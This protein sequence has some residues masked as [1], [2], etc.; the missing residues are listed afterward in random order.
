MSNV[1]YWGYRINN[2]LAEFF[3]S[4]LDNNR[5]RQGWGYNHDQDLRKEK[6]ISD[7]GA[8]R[9][10]PIFH[11]VKKGDFLLIPHLPSWD[12]IT[13]AQATEDFDKGYEYIIDK[14]YNDF[15]HIFPAKR[16]KV[17]NRHNINVSA[18]IKSTFKCVSRF[19]NIDHCEEDVQHIISLSSGDVQEKGSFQQ[20]WFKAINE[21]FD[22]KG[23]S[24]KLYAKLTHNYN[25]SDWEFMLCEGFKTLLPENVTVET[26]WNREENKHGSD[27]FIKIPGIFE[28]TY[29]I[30][31][32]IKDYDGTVSEDVVN[33]I[34]KVEE[35][36]NNHPGEQ[37]IDKYVIMTRAESCNNPKLVEAAK[38]NNVK[39]IFKAELMKLLSQMA[40]AYIGKRALKDDF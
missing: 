33:Q 31:I 14:K 20:G 34:N 29:V 2:E 13:V 37:L 25:A 39:L 8:R 6:L 24:E 22:N 38:Q 17:F 9:N 12:D 21:S 3:D 36:L 32:Q 26:T 11:K 7:D 5:L 15:G 40:K 4:E 30:A 16:I 27:L 23:F 18:N 1:H 10:I 35:Y 19:W 28:T